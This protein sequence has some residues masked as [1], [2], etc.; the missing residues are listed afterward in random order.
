ML[1]FFLFIFGLA[2]GS[3][4]NVIATRYD[5][6]HFLLNTKTL[7]GRSHCSNCKETLRW[8]ELIP[9]FS[10]VMQGGKCRTCKTKLSFQ[11]PIVE[12]VSGLIFVFV[13]L[14]I[15]I[16][17]TNLTIPMITVAAFWVIVLESLLLMTLI[18]IALGIIPD[19]LNILLGVLGILL[20]IHNDPVGRLVGALFA[21]AFFGF[22]I[23]ITK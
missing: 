22:L 15:G 13:P 7:G 6:D 23:L 1:W 16:T 20:A 5:G 4:L 10:F 9:L 2:I 14:A 19:E 18:D 17:T 3:F 21:G 11:Y 8:F 12:L